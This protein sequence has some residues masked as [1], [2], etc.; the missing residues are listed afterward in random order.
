MRHSGG[1][2]LDAAGSAHPCPSYRMAY[3]AAAAAGNESGAC[4]AV[5]A[6][7]L[8]LLLSFLFEGKKKKKGTCAATQCADMWAFS[9]VVTCDVVFI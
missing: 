8:L 9:P 3:G 1:T 7:F 5:A 6:L 4:R 2:L